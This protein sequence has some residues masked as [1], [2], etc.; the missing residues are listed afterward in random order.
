M[1][2]GPV[3]SM[4]DDRR[5]DMLSIL[6]PTLCPGAHASS[7]LCRAQA[8]RQSTRPLPTQLQN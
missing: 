5:E 3:A 2:T 8:L 7:L 1:Q 4:I 6:V